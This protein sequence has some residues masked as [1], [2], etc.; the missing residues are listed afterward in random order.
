MLDCNDL[1]WNRAVQQRPCIVTFGTHLFLVW[2]ED[3]FTSESIYEIL[4]LWILII[5]SI[6]YKVRVSTHSFF[7]IQREIELIYD[8]CFPR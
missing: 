3:V 4:L 6:H 8:K 7:N 1:N 5:H 2:R